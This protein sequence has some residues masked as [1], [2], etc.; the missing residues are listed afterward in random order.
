VA[1]AAIFFSF[2]ITLWTTGTSQKGKHEGEDTDVEETHSQQLCIVTGLGVCVSGPMLKS[3]S[4]LAK[5]LG[6][7]NFKGNAGL[8]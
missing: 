6:H 4:E 8:G 2:K 7:N 5:K 3:R 1:C